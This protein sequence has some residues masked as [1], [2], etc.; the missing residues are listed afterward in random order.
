M[1]EERSAKFKDNASGYIIGT[2]DKKTF[3]DNDIGTSTHKCM[4][5]C[6]DWTIYRILVSLLWSDWSKDSSIS[7]H[8]ILEVQQ[9]DTVKSAETIET[10]QR[11]ITQDATNTG[12]SQGN[13]STESCNG[14]KTIREM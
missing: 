3:G 8:G 13:D 6:C 7:K 2:L 5:I 12:P 11:T 14:E 10:N 9:T 1:I 4:E